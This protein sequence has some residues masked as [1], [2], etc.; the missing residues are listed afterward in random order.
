MAINKDQRQLTNETHPALIKP[1]NIKTV[2]IGFA[3]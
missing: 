2:L 3:P 1:N